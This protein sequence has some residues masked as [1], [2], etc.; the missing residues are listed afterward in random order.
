M[1]KE[2]MHLFNKFNKENKANFPCLFNEVF[3]KIMEIFW[4]ENTSIKLE[5]DSKQK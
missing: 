2:L 4:A 5:N 3:L 1:T